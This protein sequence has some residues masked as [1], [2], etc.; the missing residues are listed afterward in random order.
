MVSVGD[1][2]CP[3]VSVGDRNRQLTAPQ[4]FELPPASTGYHGLPPVTDNLP[5]IGE[6]GFSR[7][8][9]LAGLGGRSCSLAQNFYP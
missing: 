1:G 2:W 9:R 6:A 5:S 7:F 3:A 4:R 8:G